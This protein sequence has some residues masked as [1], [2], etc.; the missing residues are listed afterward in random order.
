MKAT[1][2]AFMIFNFTGKK[3]QRCSLGRAGERPALTRLYY[4]PAFVLETPDMN[5]IM[6]FPLFILLFSCKTYSE[7]CLF[8]DMELQQMAT[9]EAQCLCSNCTNAIQDRMQHLRNLCNAYI[10]CN[11]P[12]DEEE[13]YDST[14][15][16]I[17][18]S[19]SNIFSK[20]A[21]IEL[22]Q[23]AM[24]ANFFR[25]LLQMPI[26]ELK[27]YLSQPAT[28]ELLRDPRIAELLLHPALRTLL[29]LSGID[30]LK[31]TTQCTKDGC[32]VEHSPLLKD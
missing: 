13:Q 9:A 29:Y 4:S 5:K 2:A 6:V 16:R 27:C 24:F 22:L 12:E 11:L 8:C 26:G 19:L 17:R 25:N 1:E 3:A 28:L 20:P 18:K 32:L 14:M 15:A 31:M 10:L 7:S 23:N 30:T 21:V